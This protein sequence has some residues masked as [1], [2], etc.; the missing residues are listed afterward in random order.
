M[1]LQN[2]YYTNKLRTPLV[3]KLIRKKCN[4]NMLSVLRVVFILCSK[5]FIREFIRWPRN[6]VVSVVALNYDVT[7]NLCLCE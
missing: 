2:V 5:Y 3:L 7:G 4:M 1:G 6:P